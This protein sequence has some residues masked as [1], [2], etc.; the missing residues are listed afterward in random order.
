M[1]KVPMM[2]MMAVPAGRI[3]LAGSLGSHWSD[4]T[5]WYDGKERT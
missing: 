3:W 1:N 2:P 5:G 4:E